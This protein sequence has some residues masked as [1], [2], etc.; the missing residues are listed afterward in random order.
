MLNGYILKFKW[1]YAKYVKNHSNYVHVFF[2]E[3]L[4][5]CSKVISLRFIFN[6]F[7]S[8]L[9]QRECFVLY[10]QFGFPFLGLY[11]PLK[12]I[13]ILLCLLMLCVFN[14]QIALRPPSLSPVSVCS[15]GSVVN[16]L[17]HDCQFWDRGILCH[18]GQERGQVSP[19][20]GSCPELCLNQDC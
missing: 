16:Q 3:S 13:P 12:C 5:L 9:P 19:P 8:S 10:D 17:T 1:S 4:F 15:G 18:Q 7:V 14:I 6:S 2:L 20:G 11:S